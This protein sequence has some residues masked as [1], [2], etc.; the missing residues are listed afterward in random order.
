MNWVGLTITVISSASGDSIPIN[1]GEGRIAFGVSSTIMDISGV[2]KPLGANL[3]V[4]ALSISGGF[5]CGVAS[6]LVGATLGETVMN[7]PRG[8]W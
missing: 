3:G 7:I 1:L 6:I 4:T 5:W 2:I 8:L